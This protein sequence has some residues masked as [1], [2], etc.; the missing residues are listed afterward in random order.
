MMTDD[1]GRSVATG[2]WLEEA[3][4]RELEEEMERAAPTYYPGCDAHTRMH[5]A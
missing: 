2:T 4:E 3:D 1:G 5:P